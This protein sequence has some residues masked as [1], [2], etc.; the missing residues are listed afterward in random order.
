MRQFTEGISPG[1]ALLME[2]GTG[3]SLTSVAIT[4]AL[5]QAGKV[6]R[7]LIVA[8][9]SI[10]GVWQDEFAKF[11]DF[12]YTLQVLT[13]G[14]SKK[15]AAL[16]GLSGATLQIAVVNYESAWRLEQEIADWRPDM[17]ICDEG[18]KIKSHS[19]NASKAMHR[20]GA[21]AKFRLLLT[22]TPVT[23]KAVDIFSQYKFLHPGVFGTSFYAFRNRYFEQGYFPSQLTMKPHM[24]PE[25]TQRLHSIAFRATKAECLDLPE[26]WTLCAP[27]SWNPP[28]DAPTTTWCATALQSLA[29]KIPSPPPTS[30]HG[31][32][33]CRS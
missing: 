5:A 33:A 24:E 20:L 13:G 32:C 31:S 12:D 9:L 16:R 1:V 3:K 8:P 18:H 15:A 27:W 29:W 11:A 22:G 4:G 28:P 17:I 6:C 25:F 10:L 30:S 14:S 7:V 23:N 21:R 2:M 26:P 19:T